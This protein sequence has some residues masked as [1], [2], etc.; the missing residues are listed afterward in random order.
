MRELEEMLAEEREDKRRVQ[1]TTLLRNMTKQNSTPNASR[2]HAR[3]L[4]LSGQV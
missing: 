3:A 1:L 2:H 4:S